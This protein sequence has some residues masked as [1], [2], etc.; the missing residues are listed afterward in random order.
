MLK[1]VNLTLANF[2]FACATWSVL[3]VPILFAI[4]VHLGYYF[5]LMHGLSDPLFG[6]IYWSTFGLL[7]TSGALGISIWLA[8]LGWFQWGIAAL[9]WPL[10]GGA[11]L[12]VSLLVSCF[13]GDCL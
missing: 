10:M 5:D 13:N 6:F 1:S 2:R 9:Y 8:G 11:L 3:G 4:F 12:F 7:V